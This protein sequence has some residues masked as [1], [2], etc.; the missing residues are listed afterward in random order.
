MLNEERIEPVSAENRHPTKT[1]L[2]VEDDADTQEFLASLFSEV[3]NY[4]YQL[5]TDASQ[6]VNFTKGVKPNLIILDILLK[7]MNGLEL[8]DLLHATPGLETIPAIFITASYF[9]KFRPEIEKREVMVI[10]KPFD[11][12]EFLRTVQQLLGDSPS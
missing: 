2:V 8:Y 1:I 11:L 10:K 3:T 9:E 7:G 5:A 12:D 4:H 6:A